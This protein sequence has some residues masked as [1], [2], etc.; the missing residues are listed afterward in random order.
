MP[1][2]EHIAQGAGSFFISGIWQGFVLAAGVGL[3]LRLIPKT[4]ATLRF[5]IWAAVLPVIVMLPFVEHF[6]GREVLPGAGASLVPTLQLDVRWSFAIMAVWIGMSL[7]RAIDLAVH[8][9][10]LWSLRR[11][12]VPV[13]LPDESA[14]LLASSLRNGIVCTSEELNRPSVIGFFAPRILIPTWLFAK[15]SSAEL[16]Q[17]VLHEMEHL[18]RGDDWLNLLQKLSLVL[19]PL[20][21]ALLWV[22]RRLCFERELAC[23]DGVLQRTRAPRAY[24]SCLTSLAE[25][26]L[27][28]RAISLALGVFGSAMRQSELARR[29]HRILRRESTLSPLWARTLTG[30]LALGLLGGA[31]GL[32]HCPQIVSFEDSVQPLQAAGLQPAM[33]VS[34]MPRSLAAPEDRAA[35]PG[36][37]EQVVFQSP[38]APQVK[39]LTATE[40]SAPVTHRP[41]IHKTHRVV[42]PVSQKAPAVR[43]VLTSARPQPQ[44]EAVQRWVVLSSWT[45]NVRPQLIVPIVDHN[46]DGETVLLPY[47]AV[48]TAGGWFI[49]EL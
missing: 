43:Q 10:R 7:F 12:A 40:Q 14:A 27:D 26:G 11:R 48:P 13:S 33:Q 17:I 16:E 15:L 19:F 23:D 34:E 5:T 4:S 38:E 18:R 3:C 31:V 8:G 9:I 20:N 35:L 49:I 42:R 22:E 39:L 45:G 2:L 30:I 25:R 41:V 29:V 37:A 46:A 36:R 44:P 21:P 6:Y 47:A 1:G 32:A 24:A 28:H